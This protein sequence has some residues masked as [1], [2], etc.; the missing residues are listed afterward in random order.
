MRKIDTTSPSGFFDVVAGTSRSQAATLVL[1]A[2]RSTGGPDN[3]HPDSDQW[4]YV[5]SGHGRA[6]VENEE[7]EL[8]PGDLLLIE[9]GEAHEIAAADEALETINVYAP[10]VY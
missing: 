1:E 5:V 10:P 9:A 4:L 8:G 7:I 3:R 6:T 2:G